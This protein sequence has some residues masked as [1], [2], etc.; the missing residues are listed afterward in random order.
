MSLLYEAAIYP[1]PEFSFMVA[2]VGGWF[3]PTLE[4]GSI[5]RRFL[6]P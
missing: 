3:H 1:F 5:R 4:T 6:Q 2:C